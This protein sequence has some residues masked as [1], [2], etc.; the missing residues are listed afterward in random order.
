MRLVQFLHEDL[1]LTSK[2][3]SLENQ[4]L[5]SNQIL[6][7]FLS[8]KGE[9]ANGCAQFEMVNDVGS[10]SRSNFNV[11]RVN[12]AAEG[13][14]RE[15][16]ESIKLLAPKSFQ[17]QNRAVTVTDYEQ[18]IRKKMGAIETMNVWGGQDNVP[19]EYGKVFI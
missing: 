1:P 4:Q 13:S 17:A 9:K 6:I 7:S 16:I 10:I 8:T 15:G 11:T 5:A 14:E 18:L 3:H 19:P 2:E 12:R